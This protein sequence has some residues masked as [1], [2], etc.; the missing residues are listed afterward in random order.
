MKKTHTSEGNGLYYGYIVDGE[1]GST[2]TKASSHRGRKR[3]AECGARGAN[4]G[5]SDSDGTRD[6]RN[7][8][9]RSELAAY[10][11]HH[12][13]TSSTRPADFIIIE[14]DEDVSMIFIMRIA[15]VLP[16]SG[17][18]SAMAESTFAIINFSTF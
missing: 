17:C 18:C 7:P 16:P 1:E 5:V 9:G 8:T 14:L 2:A 3:R 13:Y 12:H 4:E 11:K 10:D 15:R 6:P